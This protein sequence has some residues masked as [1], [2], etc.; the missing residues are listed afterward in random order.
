MYSVKK[1]YG[2]AQI[3][4]CCGFT[5]IE[6]LVVVSVITILCGISFSALGKW[7]PNYRLKATTQ[8]MYAS[9][10]KARVYAVKTNRTVYFTFNVDPSCTGNSSYSFEDSAGNIVAGG[11]MADGICI[12]NSSFANK[13]ETDESGFD[14][15]GL[16]GGAIGKIE[17][18]HTKISR[19]RELSQSS[20]G[21]IQIN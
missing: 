4:S 5:L 21:S 11:S 14:P 16:S 17:L 9:F 13:D 3:K 1:Y 8:E 20:A 15:M 18:G 6:I 2:E 19:T 12:L 10:Q 7:V